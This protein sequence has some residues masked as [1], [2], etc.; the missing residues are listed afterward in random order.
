MDGS[1]PPGHWLPLGHDSLSPLGDDVTSLF[2]GHSLPFGQDASDGPAAAPCAAA[3][4]PSSRVAAPAGEPGSSRP[5][6][7]MT[8]APTTAV[9]AATARNVPRRR[10]SMGGFVC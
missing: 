7:A 8:A 9:D 10:G 1:S 6:A 2:G 3:D 4:P 5:A